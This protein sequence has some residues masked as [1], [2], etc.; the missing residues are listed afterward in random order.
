MRNFSLK[1][2]SHNRIAH[3]V[4]LTVSLAACGILFTNCRPPRGSGD[5]MD[6]GVVTGASALRF[7][8]LRGGCGKGELSKSPQAE[9]ERAL[10]AQ[11]AFVKDFLS[12]AAVQYQLTPNVTGICSG[13]GRNAAKAFGLNSAQTAVVLNTL[14][15]CVVERKLDANRVGF[16]VLL[17]DTPE[18]IHNWLLVASFGLFYGILDR[19]EPK[20]AASNAEH[21]ETLSEMKTA[22]VALAQTFI[23]EMSSAAETRAV[24]GNYQERYGQGQFRTTKLSDNPLFQQYVLT[25]LSDAYYCNA[26]KTWRPNEMPST[27][28]AFSKFAGKFLETK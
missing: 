27:K 7:N 24:I 28:Q 18:A 21:G 15:Y 13:S 5:T 17:K 9:L 11:P 19:S 23:D 20:D 4:C 14:T 1:N 16:T 6:L 25:E 10:S 12:K 2:V 3:S 26:E 22:R 8:F